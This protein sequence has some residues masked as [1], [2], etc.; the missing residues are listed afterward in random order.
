MESALTCWKKAEKE[1]E[2]YPNKEKRKKR[3]KRN[4]CTEQVCFIGAHPLSNA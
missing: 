2:N 4:F 1:E 3:K